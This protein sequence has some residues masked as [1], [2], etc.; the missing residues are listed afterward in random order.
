MTRPSSR[1]SRADEAHIRELMQRSLMLVI[2][3]AWC[4]PKR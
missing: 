4:D 3:T 1:Q 2:S